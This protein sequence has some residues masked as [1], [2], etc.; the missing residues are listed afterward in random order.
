MTR[1]TAALALLGLG[2]FTAC[3]LCSCS[4]P[5]S[6][7]L[8]CWEIATHAD[9]VHGQLASTIYA[10]FAQFSPSNEKGVSYSVNIPATSASSGS[11]DIY[12]QI[13]APT[14]LQWV[15]LGQ[16]GQ[17]AGAN[18]FIMYA[19]ASGSN[20]TLSPRLGTGEVEPDYDTE[21]QVFLLEGSGVANNV[22][23]ANVRCTSWNH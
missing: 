7:P 22:M 23:T 3:S 1:S 10:Q 17:M 12:F 14:S 16:G 2:T 8:S 15:G 21:A 4:L 20:V 5:S 18:I 13:Q 11:G 19:D 6:L 9:R